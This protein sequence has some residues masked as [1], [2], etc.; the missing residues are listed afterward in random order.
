MSVGQ[1]SYW[2]FAFGFSAF[3]LL[4]A[5]V[6]AIVLAVRRARRSG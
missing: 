2:S 1:G 4:M 3:A 6:L 5:V